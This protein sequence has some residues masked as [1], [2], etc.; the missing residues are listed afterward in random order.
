MCTFVLILPFVKCFFFPFTQPLNQIPAL[1]YKNK[2][3][4][5]C[6]LTPSICTANT[7]LYLHVQTALKHDYKRSSFIYQEICPIYWHLKCLLATKIIPMPNSPCKAWLLFTV[8]RLILV[9]WVIMMGRPCSS[10][11]AC[12]EW[13]VGHDALWLRGKWKLLA[14]A[15]WHEVCVD[16]GGEKLILCRNTHIFGVFIKQ[17]YSIHFA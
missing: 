3:L 9:L 17:Y 6:N 15:A 11:L 2:S 14:Y 5:I 16:G 7:S 12:T 10:I 8:M 1:D 4:N 13:A